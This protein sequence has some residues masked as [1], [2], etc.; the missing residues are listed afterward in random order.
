MAK[1]TANVPLNIAL[2]GG[3]EAI[4]TAGTTHRIPDALV[5][6]FTRDVAPLIPGGVTWI[7]QDETSAVSG[8]DPSAKYDKTGGTIT[9]AVAATGSISGASLSAIGAITGATIS[10]PAGTVGRGRF[11]GTPWHDVMAYGA[12]GDGSTDDTPAIRAAFAAAAAGETVVLPE[13]RTFIVTGGVSATAAVNLLGLNGATLKAG[14]DGLDAWMKWTAGN[15]IAVAGVRFDD[16]SRGRTILDFTS[17]TNL[18]VQ[19]CYFTGYSAAF[20]HGATDSAVRLTSVVNAKIIHSTFE[21][22]GNIYGTATSTLN[23]CVTLND[24]SCEQILIQGNHFRFVNQGIIVASPKV[25]ISGNTFYST[26]DNCVYAIEG[27]ADL[28]ITGNQFIAGEECVVLANHNSATVDVNQ[29]IVAGNLFR[30]FRNKGVTWEGPI[31]G[32][33]IE[34]NVFS[35]NSAA[36]SAIRY[37]S[38]DNGVKTNL[39]I[40]GNQI[41]GTYGFAAIQLQAISGGLVANNQV[42]IDPSAS[43]NHLVRIDG[44]ACTSIYVVSNLLINTGSSTAS[45]CLRYTVDPVKSVVDQNVLV[46]GQGVYPTTGDLFAEG[47]A[48]ICRVY[49]SGNIAV[50]STSDTTV[51]FDSESSDV[52]AMHSTITNTSRITP[53]WP[54]KWRV[55]G[56]IE[57][58]SQTTATGFRQVKLFQTGAQVNQTLL[59]A[60]TNSVS[61]T[62]VDDILTIA[63][64][65]YIE[66]VVRHNFGSAININANGVWGLSLSAEYI[67]R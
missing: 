60:I 57:W 26:G 67:G 11:K 13:G 33:S 42:Q 16:A 25:T 63:A 29:V 40:V 20:G 7:T 19:N 1:F 49:N 6:E 65:D 22:F 31:N 37:R 10:A 53:P 21:S 52:F 24:A 36:V 50:N 14:A 41:R 47:V 44:T 66:L 61:T 9:G 38:T 28:S 39:S 15:N 34:N 30:D 59:P 3:F 56:Q 12:V 46:G 35:A 27:T 5:E 4:G 58:S 51:T 64:G 18:T 55:H 45:Y 8:F 32:L 17:V 48:P 62:Q 43:T 2:P 54:G 23:R